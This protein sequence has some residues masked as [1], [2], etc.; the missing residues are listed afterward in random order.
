M[1]QEIKPINL[2]LV[3]HCF[4]GGA[5]PIYHKL[6]SYQLASLLM[7]PP[8]INVQITVCCTNGDRA[9]EMVLDFFAGRF[10]SLERGSELKRLILR[11]TNLFR[12]AIGRNR[13]ALRSESE[14]IWF[15][16]VDHV[17][18]EG[19]LDAAHAAAMAKCKNPYT[20]MVFPRA[21]NINK[22]H[23]HGDDALKRFDQFG[24]GV[25][26]IRP[27]DFV[28][29]RNKRAWGGLQIVRGD[30]CRVH[31]YLN[32]TKWQNPVDPDEGFRQCKCD[33]PFRKAVGESKAITVPN[34]YR[35]RH[36]RAGRDGG[37]KNHGSA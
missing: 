33:V 2:E 20:N 31:G 23:E 11:P 18:E 32:H 3:V 16:D 8:K 24:P 6:L 29:R 25:I 19:C 21:L 4:S 28:V 5:V 15:T 7:K 12:R 14:M 34:L 9:T 26:T 36:S 13:A 22:T 35:I 17:F 37:K 30:W 27:D 1:N 10:K